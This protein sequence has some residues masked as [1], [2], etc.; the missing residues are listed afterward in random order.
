[1]DFLPYFAEQ[2]LV[3]LDNFQDG[4]YFSSFELLD[5]ANAYIVVAAIVLEN[6]LA[7][8]GGDMY[9]RWAM[10][11]SEDFDAIAVDR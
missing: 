8:M 6:H 5:F 2:L 1:M 7:S 9:V 11:V 3:G 4:A 10:V